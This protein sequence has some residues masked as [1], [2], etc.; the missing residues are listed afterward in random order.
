MSEIFWGEIFLGEGSEGGDRVS[1]EGKSWLQV[2]FIVTGR[3]FM[4]PGGFSCF[5]WL[6]VWF[7]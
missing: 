5:L 3:Y 2:G 7:S 4:V 1:F 6:Q